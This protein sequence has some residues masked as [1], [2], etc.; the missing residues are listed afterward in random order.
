MSDTENF[1]PEHEETT[2]SKP[3]T[4]ADLL[5]DP[6]LK[7]HPQLEKFINQPIETLAKSHVHANSLIGK[8]VDQMA[9]EDLI[10]FNKKLGMPERS[11]EYNFAQE[12][13]IPQDKVRE[14][15]DKFHKAGLSVVAAEH[16]FNDHVESIRASDQKVTED[17]EAKKEQNI[18]KLVEKMGSNFKSL[19]DLVEQELIEQGGIELRDRVLDPVNMDHQLIDVFTKTVKEKRSQGL[20]NASPTAPVAYTAATAE[21]EIAMIKASPEYRAALARKDRAAL[22][23]F[24]EREL[25]LR[26]LVKLR[27]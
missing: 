23:A 17:T 8:R 5:Q 22:M 27:K 18:N 14:L 15:K 9:P 20:L 10:A 7:S 19:L 24:S 1:T 25:N 4:L 11:D 3:L 21:M 6:E 12:N 2:E 13:L 26:R 16:M